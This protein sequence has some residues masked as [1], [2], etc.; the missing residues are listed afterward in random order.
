MPAKIKYGFLCD[1]AMRVYGK[2]TY[3]GLFT[4]INSPG[5][6]AGV[7]EACLCFK[8]NG[9]IG[10]HIL[11]VKLVNSEGNVVGNEISQPIEC[12][13]FV[14]NEVV[15]ELKPLVLPA[16][17]FYNYRLSLDD[18]DECFGEIELQGIILKQT[19][20]SKQGD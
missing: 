9:P 15:V 12:R 20:P 17:G 18:D 8:F 10:P 1:G 3:Q 5:F 19:G 7:P 11:K 6:P 14:D 4:N 2:F 13:E 16:P